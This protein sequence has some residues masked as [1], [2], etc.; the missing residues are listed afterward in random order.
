MFDFGRNS[1]DATDFHLSLSHILARNL[2]A[3][4]LPPPFVTLLL[5]PDL[6]LRDGREPGGVWEEG[7]ESSEVSC[8]EQILV[9]SLRKTGLGCKY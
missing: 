5:S 8:E 2:F 1:S 7:D 9:V 6:V 3:D 4:S